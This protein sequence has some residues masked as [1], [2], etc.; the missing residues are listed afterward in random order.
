NFFT[1]I[2]SDIKDGNFSNQENISA[3]QQKFLNLIDLF[4]KNEVKRIKKEAGS[5]R[6]S[7]LFMT[8]LQETKN[9]GLFSFNLYKSQRDFMLYHTEKNNKA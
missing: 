6:N 4:R 2:T 8:I 5:T 7:L 3:E 1:H 9:L